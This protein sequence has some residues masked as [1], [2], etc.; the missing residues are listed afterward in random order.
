MHKSQT[1]PRTQNPN[2][3]DG[4][5]GGTR[6]IL[7]LS[8]LEFLKAQAREKFLQRQEAERQGWKGH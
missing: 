5:S 4:D 7:S 3:I 6:R 8:R 2:T 1:I